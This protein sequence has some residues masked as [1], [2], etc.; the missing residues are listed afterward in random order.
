[1]QKPKHIM[2]KLLLICLTAALIVIG[3]SNANAQSYDNAI[4]VRVG[5]YNGVNFKTF[6]KTNK[7]LDFNLSVRNNN[8]L[9]RV[10][11]TGLYQ[12]HNPINDAPGLQWYYGAG[13]SVGSYKVDHLDGDLFLSADGVIGLDYKIDGAPL[14]LA[15]DWRPRLALAPDP[16]FGTGDVGLAIRLTF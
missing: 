4:G 2:K 15:I 3:Q 11:L 5:S 1:V 10:I 12:V 6:I 8:H 16:D 9:K 14:N 7:A 13:A